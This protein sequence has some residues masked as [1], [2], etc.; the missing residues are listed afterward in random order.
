MLVEVPAVVV[1]I[2]MSLSTTVSRDFVLAVFRQVIG[3]RDGRRRE[4]ISRR[5]V[6]ARVDR[7]VGIGRGYPMLRVLDETLS[8]TLTI[9]GHTKL[10]VR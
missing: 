7:N 1:V 5:A 8:T 6:Q 10:S 2:V 4:R 9:H 3:R